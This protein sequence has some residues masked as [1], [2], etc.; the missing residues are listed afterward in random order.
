MQLSPFWGKLKN[1]NGYY[2]MKYTYIQ[3]RKDTKKP[4]VDI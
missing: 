3:G 2:R 1:V 4:F